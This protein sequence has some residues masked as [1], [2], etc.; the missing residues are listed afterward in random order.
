M[1]FDCQRCDELSS[2]YDKRYRVFDEGNTKINNLVDA[3]IAKICSYKRNKIVVA[4]Q[5]GVQVRLSFL[6]A[7]FIP[8]ALA[9]LMTKESKGPMT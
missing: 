8:F 5:L 9:I 6:T 1:S 4:A 7:K 3:K 2:D